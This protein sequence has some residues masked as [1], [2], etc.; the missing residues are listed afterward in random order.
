MTKALVAACLLL[1]GC[2]PDGLDET[3][4][5]DGSAI[6]NGTRTGHTIRLSAPQR[7]AIGWLHFTETA[8]QP[9][10]T[11]TL[12]GPRTIIT[13]EHCTR[14]MAVEDLGFSVGSGPAS[15]DGSF[16][17]ELVSSHSRVDISVVRLAATATSGMESIAPLPLHLEPITDDWV[18]MWVDGAGH[19]ETLSSEKGLFFAKTEIVEVG[20]E[21]LIV[22]GHGEQGICYGD[23]G[24]P[25]LGQIGGSAQI[26]GIES[27]GSSSCLGRDLVIRLDRIAGWL[28]EATSGVETPAPRPAADRRDSAVDSTHIRGCV[29]A[30]TSASGASWLPL[31]ASF[32]FFALLW[33]RRTP[34]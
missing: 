25:I 9:W 24:G 5:T 33:R 26:I 27:K 12:I 6:V 22:D 30:T 18:G 4:R 21:D 7:R 29:C 2:G 32:A 10:C 19:G 28:V 17:L 11:A 14:G 8:T 34:A 3:W 1:L 15:I 13:A 20:E 23:S 16:G 31:F